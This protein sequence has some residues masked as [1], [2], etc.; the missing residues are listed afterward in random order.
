MIF[1]RITRRIDVFSLSVP[2]TLTSALSPW[3]LVGVCQE[4]VSRLWNVSLFLCVCLSSSRSIALVLAQRTLCPGYG[5]CSAY[6]CASIRTFRM[7][8]A[9]TFKSLWL[10]M[11]DV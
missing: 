3:L 2:S 5:E 10:E 8:E 11:G 6:A 4:S 7:H 9:R 1:K